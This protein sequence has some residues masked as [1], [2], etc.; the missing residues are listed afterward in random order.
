[1]TIHSYKYLFMKAY[2]FSLLVLFL[3]GSYAFSQSYSAGT[4]A[5]NGNAGLQNTSVGSYAGS[6]LIGSSSGNSALGKNAGKLIS[7]GTGNVAA[8]FNAGGSMTG[9]HFCTFLG[10]YAGPLST[11]ASLGNNIVLGSYSGY[12]ATA[13]NYNTYL[14]YASGYSATT[15][16]SN[17]FIGY[18]AGYFETGSNKLYIENSDATVPLIGADLVTKQVGINVAPGTYALNIGGTLNATTLFVGGQPY[19]GT[20]W[21]TSGNNINYTTGSVAIGT[22]VIPSDFKLAVG[23]TV[24]AEEIVVKLQSNWPDYVFSPRYKLRSLES[25]ERYVDRH[26][27]LP[28]VPEASRVEKEGLS[29]G[30][31]NAILLKQVEELT[32]QIIALDEKLTSLEN[33]K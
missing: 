18:K 3:S 10:Y 24:L 15:G 6:A 1:M 28:D 9:N 32:L 21:L 11:G 33:D 12:Q 8:G 27:H 2:T 22:A 20:Q 23:G 31:M 4:S 7:S 14:G 5:G 16:S 17:L 30:E 13:S 25:L 29:L 26:R 19:K